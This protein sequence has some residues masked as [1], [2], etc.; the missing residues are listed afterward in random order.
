MGREIVLYLSVQA[1]LSFN[2]FLSVLS[3]LAGYLNPGHTMILNR[4]LA[5]PTTCS[6]YRVNKKPNHDN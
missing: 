6:A 3:M 1:R 4:T 5:I 2:K